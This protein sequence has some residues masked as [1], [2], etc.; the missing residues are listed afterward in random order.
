[1][2]RKN[3]TRH[4]LVVCACGLLCSC[5][6]KAS[7][8]QHIEPAH[9][10]E[11]EGKHERKLTLTP[12]AFERLDIQVAEIKAGEAQISIPYSSLIYD[13]MGNVWVYTNPAQ[14]EFIREQIEVDFIKNEQVYLSKAPAP[15]TRVVVRG[16][17]ELYGTE[18][19]VGH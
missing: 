11:V 8:Y 1:M 7:I 2:F 17:A 5:Q 3:L 15:G 4:L 12:K 10:T 9:I 19:E 13:A 14:H 6:P 18:Y 16:V